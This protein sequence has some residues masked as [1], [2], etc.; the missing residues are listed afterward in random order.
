MQ[1][2]TIEQRNQSRTE[3]AQMCVCWQMFSDHY[4][5]LLCVLAGIPRIQYVPWVWLAW[6][7][8]P[9][10]FRLQILAIVNQQVRAREERGAA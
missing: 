9:E 1:P 5:A 6:E 3:S 2:N 7:Y 8:I 4:R 10:E